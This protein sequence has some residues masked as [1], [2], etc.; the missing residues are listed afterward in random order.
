MLDGTYE[1]VIV[2]NDADNGVTGDEIS[3][4]GTDDGISDH[5]MTT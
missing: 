2:E 3:E 1:R 4:N 5:E